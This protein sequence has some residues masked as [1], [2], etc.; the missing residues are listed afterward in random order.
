MTDL[1]VWKKAPRN[2]L[3]KL[4][5]RKTP[6]FSQSRRKTL[7][8]AN[9]FYRFQPPNFPILKFFNSQFPTTTQFHNP[10]HGCWNRPKRSRASSQTKWR[11]KDLKCGQGSS[12]CSLD[13]AGHCAPTQGFGY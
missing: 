6:N 4:A 8:L 1:L 3:L 11:S 7:Q 5:R 10:R 2:E 9:T 13:C 12:S